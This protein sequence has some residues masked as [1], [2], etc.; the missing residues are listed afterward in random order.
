ME[1]LSFVPLFSGSEVELCYFVQVTEK[2]DANS[3][4]SDERDILEDNTLN[5]FGLKISL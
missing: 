2:E 5:Q 4:L 3:Q 1:T